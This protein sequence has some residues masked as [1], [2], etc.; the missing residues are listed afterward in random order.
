[1]SVGLSAVGGSVAGGSVVAMVGLGFG[2]LVGG[3]GVGG[4][5]VGGTGVAVGLLSSGRLVKVTYGCV[6]V[7]VAVDVDVWLGVSVFSSV[8]VGFGVSDGCKEAVIVKDAVGL[9]NI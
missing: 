1:M 6:A 9:K 8:T 2:V 3:T 5:G 7:G 4:I